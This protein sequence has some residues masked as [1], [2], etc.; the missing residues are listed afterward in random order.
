MSRVGKLVLAL[1]ILLHVLK[2]GHN[3]FLRV[4]ELPHLFTFVDLVLFHELVNLLLLL[5]EDLVLLVVITGAGF[6][7]FVAQICLNFAN[8]PLILLH[9]LADV[10]HLLVQL[11]HVLVVLLDAVHKAFASLGERK[12][13]LVRLQLEILLALLKDYLFFAKM[14]GALL[15]RILLQTSLCRLQTVLSFIKFTPLECNIRV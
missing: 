10:V 2:E 14:L 5:V 4:R 11:L 8:I 3:G 1:Q 9:D 7:G 13:H 15:K 6:F 12:I